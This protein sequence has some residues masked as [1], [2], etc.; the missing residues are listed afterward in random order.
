M[1]A[2]K[3]REKVAMEEKEVNEGGSEES[4]GREK[5][6]VIM[7][8]CHLHKRIVQKSAHDLVFS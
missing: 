4:G 3:I 8:S 6:E 1:R 5:E 2:R 7:I